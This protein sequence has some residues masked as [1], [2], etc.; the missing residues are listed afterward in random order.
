[1]ASLSTSVSTQVMSIQ[2]PIAA[3]GS[4]HNTWTVQTNRAGTRRTSL[5]VPSYAS[6]RGKASVAGEANPEARAKLHRARQALAKSK[7][8]TSRA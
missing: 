6:Q 5:T 8:P 1:M 7:V 3:Y 4:T 2:S